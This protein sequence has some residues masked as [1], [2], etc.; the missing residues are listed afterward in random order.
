MTYSADGRRLLSATWS[1]EVKLWDTSD[2]RCILT[3]DK[4]DNY[5]DQTGLSP[6]GGVIARGSGAS[7]TLHDVSSATE[8]T[9]G[10]PDR[11]YACT[12]SPDGRRMVTL[13]L[14]ENVVLVWKVGSSFTSFFHPGAPPRQGHGGSDPY[15]S[16]NFKLGGDGAHSIILFLSTATTR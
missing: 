15:K 11:V 2:W 4:T 6:D 12:F 16:I 9:L 3:L 7:L 5:A 1:G 13:S 8:E 10:F 14:D